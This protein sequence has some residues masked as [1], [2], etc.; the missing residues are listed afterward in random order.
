LTIV[1][2]GTALL[3]RDPQ[4]RVSVVAV[5]AGSRTTVKPASIICIPFAEDGLDAGAVRS[6]T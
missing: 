4:R 6:M 1:G 3:D 2:P 5:V